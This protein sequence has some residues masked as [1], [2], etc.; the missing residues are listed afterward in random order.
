MAK[1]RKKDCVGK[2]VVIIDTLC[3]ASCAMDEN[4]KP[5]PILYDTELN[6]YVELFDDAYSMLASHK[7]SGTL[8]E[9]GGEVTEDQLEEMRKIYEGNDPQQ[10][11]SF[12]E[13]YPHANYND[14]H[15]IS[16]MDCKINNKNLWQF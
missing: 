12:L 10:M 13:K 1:I 8:S 2:F 5:S 9:W 16:A 14:E 6:A 7:E 3:G 4:D 15:V 11:K